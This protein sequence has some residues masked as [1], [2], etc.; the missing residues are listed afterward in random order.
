MSGKAREREVAAW[1]R[2]Q[3]GPA[4]WKHI[5]GVVQSA[6]KLARRFGLP[7][8]K[9][10]LAAWLHDCAKELPRARMLA[11]MRGTPFR[12]DAGERALPALWHPHAGAAIAWKKWGVRDRG[13][14]EAVRCHTLG[15]E[16]MGPLAQAI[17]VAD[18]IEPGRRFPGVGEARRAARESLAG[19]VRAKASQTVALLLSEGRLVHPRLLLTWNAFVKKDRP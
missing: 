18:F 8:G 16:R 9:A 3:V 19:G 10:R 6:E 11:W 14:L 12:L 4:R 1:V 17:F 2:T 7:V 15:G 13:L 5:Q